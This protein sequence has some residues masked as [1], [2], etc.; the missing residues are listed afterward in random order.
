MTRTERTS[1]GS[2]A[3]VLLK[4]VLLD[5]PLTAAR[6]GLGIGEPGE[7]A[8]LLGDGYDTS[9]RLAGASVD[10]LYRDPRF[11]AAA[12][13]AIDRLLRWQ[14]LAEAVRGA[15]FSALW[16]GL[17]LATA[18]DARALR[19]EIRS[20]RESLATRPGIHAAAPRP[21]RIAPASRRKHRLPAAA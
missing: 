11:E 21:P 14:R 16:R 2:E 19:R 3:V 12:A 8:T 15:A 18:A 10:A 9:V 6:R 17:G 13:G 4:T 1:P 20:L 5:L 7:L